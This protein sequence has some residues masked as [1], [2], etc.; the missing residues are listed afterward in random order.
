MKYKLLFLYS[1]FCFTTVAAQENIYIL[2]NKEKGD[3]IKEEDSETKKFY[4]KPA[5]DASVFTYEAQNQKKI[6]V[7]YE[8][9][10]NKIVSKSKANDVVKEKLEQE[11]LKFEKEAGLKGNIYRNPPY[12]FKSLFKNIFIYVRINSNKG[13][14]YEVIWDYAIQ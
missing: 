1:L 10:K 7:C 5:L 9:Y 11:A 12:D 3:L 13:F 4:L 6:R 2:F 14:L 8:K